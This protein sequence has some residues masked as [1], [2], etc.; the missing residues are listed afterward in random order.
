MLGEQSFEYVVESV[1]EDYIMWIKS[2]FVWKSLSQISTK[3]ST[4]YAF[5]GDMELKTLIPDLNTL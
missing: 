4:L 3:A 1:E 2:S 5:E